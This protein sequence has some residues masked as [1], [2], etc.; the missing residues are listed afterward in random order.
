[1]CND[2]PTAND[3]GKGCGGGG[4]EKKQLRSVSVE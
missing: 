4:V 3:Y 1:V 2:D